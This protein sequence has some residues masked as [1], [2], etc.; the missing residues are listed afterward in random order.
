MKPQERYEKMAVVLE[1]LFPNARVA[2]NYS[3]TYELLF[4]VILS[5]Q[6]TDKKVNE[7]TEK[8]FKKYTTLDMFADTT[9]ELLGQDIRST[10]FYMNKAKNI[11]AAAQK[12]R[13]E[14]GGEVPKSMA[15]MI[16]LPGVA[17]K[18]A[19]VVLS[20]AYGINEGIAVDTHMIRLCNKFGLTTQKDPVKIEQDLMKI[21]P[22]DQ[23][24][25]F[26]MRL[27]LYGREY[28]PA[29]KVTSD[30]D[31]ISQSLK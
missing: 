13:S 10:G 8:L 25:L 29:H 26:S 6:C 18:S 23:W 2:L 12:L 28:S 19:N 20:E 7:V 16:T 14:F 11:I 1:K 30:E 15:E 5:A 3:S 31:P 24:R 4:A 22:K 21:I 9:P 17:R 27:V